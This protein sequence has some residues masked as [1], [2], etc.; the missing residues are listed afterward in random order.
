MKGFMK[1]IS[2]VKVNDG[3]W[4]EYIRIN[5]ETAIPYQW[6]ALND[7]VAGAQINSAIK[8]LEIAAGIKD[9]EFSGMIF[10]DS[11]IA[12]WLE[13]VGYLLSDYSDPELEQKADYVIDLMEKAQQPDGYLNTYFIL[14]NEPR[15]ANLKDQHELYCLGHLIEGAV[16]Y[17]EATGK[18]KIIDIVCRYADLVDSMFGTDDGKIKGYPGHQEIELALYKLWE[19]TGNERYAK[20]AA[21]FINERGTEP[22]FFMQEWEKRCKTDP[23]AAAREP[24][25]AYHQAHKP[26]RQQTEAVGHAVRA[27]YMYA[28]MA[29][30]ARYTGDKTLL[31]ACKVLFDNIVQKNMY[32]TA[33]IGQTHIREAFT[34]DYDLPNDTAYNETCASIALVF[35]A[36][37]MLMAEKDGKYADVIETAIYNGTISGMSLDGR[38]YFY[39]NALSVNPK[40]SE[41]N[42]DKLHVKS[43]RQQWFRCA[44]CPPNLARLI[45]SI[46]KYIYSYSDN[47]LYVHQYINSETD[48]C[49]GKLTQTSNYPWD[50]S[51]AINVSSEEAFTLALRIPGWCKNARIIVNN[52]PCTDAPVNGYVYIKNFAGGT[53]TLSLEMEVEILRTNKNVAANA[54]KVC[55]KRGPVVYCLEEKDNGAHLHNLILDV[56]KKPEAVYDDTFLN[57][58]VIIKAGGWRETSDV[59][60]LYYSIESSPDEISDTELLFVPYYLWGNRG[61]GE[62]EVW[63][64][65]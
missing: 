60:S 18:R 3:F 27:V 55:L 29:D 30:T 54:G 59:G 12:K 38:R 58:A 32:V 57:G 5:K 48:F 14:K 39:V 64:R 16:A 24:S 6:S 61:E 1:E 65:K 36:E 49:G 25:L 23:A 11:D 19:V 10:Q 37:R 41:L 21:Y 28:G 4:G 45:A 15:F 8:N 42:P 34:F 33:G 63:V 7:T 31:D 44:C 52:K 46:G 35:F 13:A 56:T 40:A 17:Y 22:S 2:N 47:T 26:V 53:I 20:L 43:T 62:M 9:G 51:I 50:G